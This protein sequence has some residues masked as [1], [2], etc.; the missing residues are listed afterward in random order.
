MRS[1]P[2][3]VAELDSN[4]RWVNET[5]LQLI[6]E[7]ACDPD[8]FGAG[9]PGREEAIKRIRRAAGRRDGKAEEKAI[10]DRLRVEV[11]EYWQDF[12]ELQLL[13]E[14]FRRAALRKKGGGSPGSIDPPTREEGLRIARAMLGHVPGKGWL[15]FE[16]ETEILSTVLAEDWLRAPIRQLLRDYIKVS[17]SNPVYFDALGL[18]REDLNS[19]GA[20]IPLRLSKWQGKVDGGLL[21]RPSEKA[22]SANRPVHMN[23]YQRDLNIQLTIEILRRIG[24]S[25][26]GSSVSGCEIVS[27]ALATSEDEAL[28]LSWDR[29]RRIWQERTLKRSFVPVMEKYSGAIAERNGLFHTTKR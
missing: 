11:P 22:L 5:Y 26:E 29:V 20:T 28:H 6:E 12:S 9:G 2:R 19:R 25:P 3:G 21:R 14:H 23:N 24:I 10:V 27:D 16:E 13:G 17:Q 18:I 4:N 8:A 15:N 1:L 7:Y